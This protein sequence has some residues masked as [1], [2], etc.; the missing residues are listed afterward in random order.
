MP[1]D[2]NP[3][4]RQ[5]LSQQKASLYFPYICVPDGSVQKSTNENTISIW[6]CKQSLMFIF[7][8]RYLNLPY[9]TGEPQYFKHYVILVGSC[10]I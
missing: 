3:Y 6:H 1:M 8:T 9:S 10:V 4:P 5:Q 2:V 7:C